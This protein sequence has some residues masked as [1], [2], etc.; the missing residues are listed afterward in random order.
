MKGSMRRVF[1]PTDGKLHWGNATVKSSIDN[2]YRCTK[3]GELH[4]GKNE[5]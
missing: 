4:G 5:G 2:M 3:C 1:C